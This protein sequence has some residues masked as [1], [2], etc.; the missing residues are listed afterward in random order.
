M[1]DLGDHDAPIGA[2]TIDRRTHCMSSRTGR[3][4]RNTPTETTT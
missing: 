3:T 2:I 4:A 1:A